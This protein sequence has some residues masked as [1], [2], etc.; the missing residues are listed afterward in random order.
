MTTDPYQIPQLLP[1]QNFLNKLYWLFFMV[2][3][4]WL[5]HILSIISIVLQYDSINQDQSKSSQLYFLF[6]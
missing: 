1:K 5:L 6:F 4:N 2:I 3:W